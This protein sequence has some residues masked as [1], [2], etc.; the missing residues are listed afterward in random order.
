MKLRDRRQTWNLVARAKNARCNEPAVVRGQPQAKVE[1]CG[2]REHDDKTRRL[3]VLSARAR[4]ELFDVIVILLVGAFKL[5]VLVHLSERP[6][7]RPHMLST[8]TR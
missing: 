8:V 7:L 3:F 5:V 2:D 4:A 1:V 6:E